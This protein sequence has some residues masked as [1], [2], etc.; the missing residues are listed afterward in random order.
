VPIDIAGDYLEASV[1]S[2]RPLFPALP[3]LPLEG[4]FMRSIR[5]PD[6]LPAG[7]RLGFFPGSTIGNMVPA[8]AVDL[9]RSFREA[10]GNGCWLLIGMDRR[11]DVD[12]L[13]RA[14]D[15]SAGITAA[16]NLNLLHRMNAELDACIDISAFRHKAVWNDLKSRVEMHLEALRDLSFRVAGRTFTLAAGE[17]IHTE[18]SHKY[19][20]RDSRLLLEAAGWR[21]HREWVDQEGNFALIIAHAEAPRIAP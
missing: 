9:L 6:G 4:D 11:K 1:E 2:L 15:D 16:F 13:L 5:L 14:Y 18:N 10:L 7:P 21:P 17:T 3:I 19:G 12:T 8:T 20:L